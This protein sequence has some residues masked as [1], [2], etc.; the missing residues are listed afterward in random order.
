MPGWF[1]G[2]EFQNIAKKWRKVHRDFVEVPVQFTKNIM[3]EGR[4]AF[5]LVSNISEE[6]SDPKELELLKYSAAGMYGGGA[7]TVR[8]FLFC[9]EVMSRS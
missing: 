5:C 4:A 2:G 9:Q 8:G 6:V 1:P 7:D 3:A